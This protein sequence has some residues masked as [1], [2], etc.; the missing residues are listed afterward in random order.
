MRMWVQSLAWISRLRIWRCCKLWD[1]LQMQLRCGVAVAQASAVVLAWELP[2]ATGL[3]GKKQ[4]QT[5]QP[6]MS[7]H[8]IP[9]RLAKMLARMYSSKNSY[10][11]LG[12]MQVGSFFFF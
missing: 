1:R 2:Y 7:R 4:K 10:S 8:Y 9:K 12:G 11:L 6:T 3:V 5:K